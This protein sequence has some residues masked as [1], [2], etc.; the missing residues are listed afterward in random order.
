MPH[1]SGRPKVNPDYD[2]V[3]ARDDLASAV[4]KVYL[5]PAS[6]AVTDGSGRT[7][8][9]ELQETFGLSMTKIRKLLVTAGVYTFPKT[10][11]DGRTVEMVSEVKRL[12]DAGKSIEEIGEI[13]GVSRGT[14]T[15]FLP[16]QSGTYNADFTAD[17]YDYTNVSAEARRKR[18]QRKRERMERSAFMDEKREKLEAERKK[19]EGFEPVDTGDTGNTA[20]GAFPSAS[21]VTASG[22]IHPLTQKKA[23]EAASGEAREKTPAAPP[24]K[25]L[26]AKYVFTPDEK[27]RFAVLDAYG[28]SRPAVISQD[29][30]TFGVIDERGERHY[31]AVF[32]YDISRPNQ[33]GYEAVEIHPIERMGEK[34]QRS[35]RKSRKPWWEEPD[36]P[37]VELSNE[38]G[39]WICTDAHADVNNEFAIIGPAADEDTA[40]LQLISKTVR[41]LQNLTC[42]KDPY[43]GTEQAREVGYLDISDDENGDIFFRVDGKRMDAQDVVDL[44]GPY[45]GYE[46]IYGHRD[47]CATKILERG[48]TVFPLQISKLTLAKELTDLLFAMTDR[49]EGTF[50]HRED[51]A[52]FDV[53]FQGLLQKLTAYVQNIP[54]LEGK[55]AGDELIKIL[56][57]VDTDDAAFPEYE[58][59]LVQ[60]AVSKI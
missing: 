15:S 34:R 50:L 31:F 19:K 5:H 14:V 37:E 40:L 48:M 38:E 33:D 30:T 6:A 44:F 60:D 17:G 57:R 43:T 20:A 8:M 53:L 32:Q 35:E 42:E 1:P 7:A 59:R 22:E 29:T 24:E 11:R 54:I 21:S 58:I 51:V 56:R 36:L 26:F 41:S 9:K 49:H 23:P 3:K 18:N 12:R 13:L 39:H 16:Y 10:L 28:M 25:D 2:P 4:A 47:H 45:V 52:A 55:E 46:L 27:Q